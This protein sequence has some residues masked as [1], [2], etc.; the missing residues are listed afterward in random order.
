MN[1][2]ADFIAYEICASK[3]Y[4]TRR[5]HVLEQRKNDLQ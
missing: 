1:M 3:Y 2:T 5:E 4:K